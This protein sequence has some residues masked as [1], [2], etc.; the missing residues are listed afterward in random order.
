MGLRFG[1]F[2]VTDDSA[3]TVNIDA[4]DLTDLKLRDTR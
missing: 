4:D 3:Y 2:E 1:L